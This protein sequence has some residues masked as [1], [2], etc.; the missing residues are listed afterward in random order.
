MPQ[1]RRRLKLRLVAVNNATR[2]SLLRTRAFRICAM[3][4]WHCRISRSQIGVVAKS[5]R[6]GKRRRGARGNGVDG[7]SR[8]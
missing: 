5:A 4:C 1:S 3:Y 2:I 6:P 8:R 7:V